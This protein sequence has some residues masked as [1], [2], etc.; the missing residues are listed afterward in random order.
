MEELKTEIK[1]SPDLDKIIDGLYL[2]QSKDVPG[3]ALIA[4]LGKFDPK[5]MTPTPS[6]SIQI[7]DK[8]PLILKQDLRLKTEYSK[9][10]PMTTRAGGGMGLFCSGLWVVLG[11]KGMKKKQRM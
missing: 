3:E 6:F 2:C 11:E 8:G 7:R 5:E 4:Q 1:K 10:R 9:G